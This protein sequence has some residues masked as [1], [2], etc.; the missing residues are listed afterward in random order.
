MIDIDAHPVNCKKKNMQTGNNDYIYNKSKK[1]E[2]KCLCQTFKYIYFPLCTFT[3]HLKAQSALPELTKYPL[4][5]MYT[6]FSSSY[7]TRHQRMWH[8][9]FFCYERRIKVL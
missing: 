1:K 9:R 2:V 8:T 6:L 3:A 5:H 4:T 7:L